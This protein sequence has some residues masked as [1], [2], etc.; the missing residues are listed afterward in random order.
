MIF[1]SLPPQFSRCCMSMSKTGLSRRA[2]PSASRTRD[3]ISESR[4][5]VETTHRR[6]A[7]YRH[8]TFNAGFPAANLK[9]RLSQPDPNLPV[10]LLRSCPSP[11]PASFRF[12]VRKAAAR[13][14][15]DPAST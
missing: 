5:G 13:D 3:H 11:G 2:R 12:C 7:A 10:R 14:H 15:Q 9:G 4:L 8:R 6:G 1:G